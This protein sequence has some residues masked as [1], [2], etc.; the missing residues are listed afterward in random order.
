MPYYEYLHFGKY[1]ICIPVT[2]ELE[3]SLHNRRLYFATYTFTVLRPP[4]L[5][6]VLAAGPIAGDKYHLQANY[7]FLA[8]FVHELHAQSWEDRCTDGRM[9]GSPA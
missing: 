3:R 1:H 8:L 6:T 7:S 5:S 4:I 2:N 9:R